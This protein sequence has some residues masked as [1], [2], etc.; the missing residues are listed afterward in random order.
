MRLRARETCVN[1]RHYHNRKRS[2][3]R[4]VGQGMENQVK[5][6]KDMK[7]ETHH[8]LEEHSSTLNNF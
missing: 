5:Y 7:K 8:S 3:Q 1:V 2:R 6:G 4:R